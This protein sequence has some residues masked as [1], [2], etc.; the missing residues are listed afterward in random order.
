MRGTR[1]SGD[2]LCGASEILV[3]RARQGIYFNIVGIKYMRATWFQSSY[4]FILNNT[5]HIM[6][7]LT[8]YTFLVA[9]NGPRHHHPQLLIQFHSANI[10]IL[11]ITTEKRETTQRLTNA[12]KLHCPDDKA[13]CAR[14]IAQS[15]CGGGGSDERR[16]FRRCL[17]CCE[18]ECAERGSVERKEEM[19][20]QLAIVASINLRSSVWCGKCS[21]CVHKYY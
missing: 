3:C 19:I 13:H 9:H 4:E 1:N 12:A 11:I 17:V 14:N 21:R 2:N 8:M 10:Y 18:Y 20:C 5:L 6:S 16:R 7:Q 15:S